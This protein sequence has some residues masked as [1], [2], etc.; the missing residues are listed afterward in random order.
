[1]TPDITLIAGTAVDWQRFVSEINCA[2]SRSPTRELDKCEI[3]VG[4]PASY[5]AALAEFHKPG[6]NPVTAIKDSD[7][8]LAH[9]SFTF[10]VSV[11]Q[12]VA[13]AILKQSV[14]LTVLA[15]EPSKGRENLILT[16]S[17]RDWRTATVE[18]C[19]PSGSQE[20]RIFYNAL[21]NVFDKMGFRE[22]FARYI[23]RELK[24]TTFALE[25]RRS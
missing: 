3:P 18:G 10:L 11:D 21:W 20:A 1:M 2:L 22:A 8:A 24:D 23:R 25:A 19:S 15:A 6:S 12:A 13:M 4:G 9:L 16:G 5:I 17:L 7:K 14:G